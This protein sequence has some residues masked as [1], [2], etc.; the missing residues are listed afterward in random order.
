MNRGV[1]SLLA[2]CALFSAACS[3]HPAGLSIASAP[4]AEWGAAR[5]LFNE[6][7]DYP[8]V[9]T[10]L[11]LEGGYKLVE[12]WKT[13]YDGWTSTDFHWGLD[14]GDVRYCFSYPARVENAAWSANGFAQL[15]QN[16]DGSLK[17]TIGDQFNAEYQRKNP[18]WNRQGTVVEEDR[19]SG[20]HWRIKRVGK[21]YEIT[22]I[23]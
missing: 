22:I 17:T 21:L 18:T 20:V 3:V 11:H 2:L 23:R 13:R 10:E 4:N 8:H 1:L 6:Q 7:T 14:D 19:A 15:R 9:V 5:F 16:K 12:C